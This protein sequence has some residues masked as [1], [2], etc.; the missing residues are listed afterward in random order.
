[1]NSDDD[2]FDEVEPKSKSQRKRDA[3]AAQDLGKLLVEM[4]LPRFKTI[5]GK[6][7]LPHPLREALIACRAITAHGGRRRQLQYI[8]KLMR[9]IDTAPIEEAIAM[10]EGK[11][12]ASI[13]AQH[14]LEYWRERLIDE[15]DAALA[16]WMTDHPGADRQQL[17]QL[18]SK[19]RKER[20]AGQPPTAARALFRVLR[21]AANSADSGAAETDADQ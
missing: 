13:A 21:E 4:P 12:Q 16:E 15:G 7:D 11:H 19:A 20:D 9:A 2:S 18:I 17:R 8:G 6:L 5:M 3:E 1:M 14:R 10:L